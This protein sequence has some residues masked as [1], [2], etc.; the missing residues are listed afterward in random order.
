MDKVFKI[1]PKYWHYFLTTL[2]IGIILGVIL[3][4]IVYHARITAFNVEGIGI[5]IPTSAPLPTQ[6]WTPTQTPTQTA[7][8][9]AAGTAT[10]TATPT[11]TSV[12]TQTPLFS[13]P[14][15]LF[16]PVHW[17]LP[18]NQV[19]GSEVAS[20]IGDQKLLL[21]IN[22][23]PSDQY[24]YCTPSVKLQQ[25]VLKDFDL[26]FDVVFEQQSVHA[27]PAIDVR[28]RENQ[29]GYFYSLHVNTYG[30]YY[31]DLDDPDQNP[32]INEPKQLPDRPDLGKPTTIRILA[33]DT[34]FTIFENG[35]P[36]ENVNDGRLNLFGTISFQYYVSQ[37][38]T[39]T[40]SIRNF[41]I[42]GVP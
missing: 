29:G 42:N 4:L 16:D 2:V 25:P 24:I 15:L 33:N 14:F 5:V 26:S 35:H 11:L 23:P 31:F 6:T 32:L 38:E 12:P 19:W 41:N 9:T 36:I 20:S 39:A 13:D 28:F 40:I 18:D 10:A 27:N 22:C 21:A 3:M 8:A 37:G 34:H 7:Q 30:D 1:I 17:V